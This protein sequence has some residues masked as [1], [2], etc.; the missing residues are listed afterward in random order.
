MLITLVQYY[1]NLLTS[2]VPI[3]E[4]K[5]KFHEEL[6]HFLTSYSI[7]LNDI[8]NLR[9]E[10]D[11][12]SLELF[13]PP[14]QL[15]TKYNYDFTKINDNK[16]PFMR[17]KFNYKRPYGWKRFA[18]KVLDK[19]ED[20]TWLGVEGRKSGQHSTQN[21]W[22]GIIYIF[23]ITIIIFFFFHKMIYLFI[24]F[25]SLLSWNYHT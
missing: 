4:L 19:Y 7:V 20:N 21:E 10:V 11:I 18:L 3:F 23:F 13:I 12:S 1:L 9:S 6:D 22:P 25:I 16:E 24:Y 2:L 8:T 14:D 15:D 5:S 17:G